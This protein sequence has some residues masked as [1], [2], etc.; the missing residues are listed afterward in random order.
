[1]KIRHLF[2]PFLKS[3]KDFGHKKHAKYAP[4][5]NDVIFKNIENNCD[6]KFLKFFEEKI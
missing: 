2:C 4:D 6:C 3:Q 5:H 1:M